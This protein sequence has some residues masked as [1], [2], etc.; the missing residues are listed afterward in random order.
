[1]IVG[2]VGVVVGGMGCVG[3]STGVFFGVWCVLGVVV[4]VLFGIYI[5]VIVIFCVIVE[6]IFGCDWL[7][8]EIIGVDGGVS[9]V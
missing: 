7:D 1:M 9:G 5:G 8:W 2:R 3:F 6:Q 4:Y